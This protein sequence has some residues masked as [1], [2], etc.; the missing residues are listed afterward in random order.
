M[1]K[2]GTI[3]QMPNPQQKDKPQVDGLDN[4]YYESNTPNVGFTFRVR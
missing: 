4:L 1:L 2:V 3:Y